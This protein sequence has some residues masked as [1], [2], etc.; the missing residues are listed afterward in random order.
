MFRAPSA[1]VVALVDVREVEAPYARRR[2]ARTCAAEVELD[3]RPP[4][5]RELE[6]EPRV[7]W[8]EA[9]DH[10]AEGRLHRRPRCD[11]AGAHAGRHRWVAGRLDRAYDAQ[12]EGRRLERH[13]AAG[14]VAEREDELNL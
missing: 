8:V 10:E 5:L 13:G 7:G 4:A 3:R 14:R 11:H 12:S 1:S 2:A 6:P 9:R